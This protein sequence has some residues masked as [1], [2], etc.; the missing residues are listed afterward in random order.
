MKSD[1]LVDA[2][3]GVREDYLETLCEG[4]EALE[5]HEGGRGMS[6]RSFVRIGAAAAAV[7]VCAFLGL[8]IFGKGGEKGFVLT[9]YAEGIEQEDGSR[10]PFASF[11]GDWCEGAGYVDGM[12]EAY[13]SFKLGCDV[14]G[15]GAE[16]I[17]YTLEGPY[18]RS[19]W[20][21][22]QDGE[23]A[24]FFYDF[25]PETDDRG[26]AL[27]PD[28]TET[29]TVPYT[30][31]SVSQAIM[32]SF[33]MSDELREANSRWQAA[34]DAAKWT[35]EDVDPEME[36]AMFR[37]SRMGYNELLAATTLRISVAYSDGTVLEKRY[38]ITPID[39]FDEVYGAW[40]DAENEAYE[41]FEAGLMSAEEV[42]EA[43]AKQPAL[44]AVRELEG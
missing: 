34:L 2:I 16:S 13:Y 9:A 41:A 24:I 26:F 28:Y 15:A 35:N 23:P 12:Y 43:Y 10:I 7:G 40:L 44:Y 8:S 21:I 1:K 11:A 30:G 3:G 33:P 27:T 39:D 38:A 4:R 36:N 29:I 22:P 14:E 20:D 42:N 18:A 6:R 31:K 25:N 17:T 32:A 37:L 19:Y 5:V